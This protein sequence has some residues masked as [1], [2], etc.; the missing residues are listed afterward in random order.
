[1]ILLLLMPMTLT[2]L[3]LMASPGITIWCINFC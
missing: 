3:M 2:S 1:V